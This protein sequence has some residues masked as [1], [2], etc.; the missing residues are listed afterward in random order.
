MTGVL[1]VVLPVFGLLGL[2]YAAARFGLLSYQAGEGLSEFVFTFCIPPLIFRTM[3]TASL[4]DSQPWGYWGAYFLGLALTWALAMA[5]GRG[6]FKLDPRENV[7]AGFSAAQSNTA[8]VGIP[9]LLQAF[10]D[11]GAVPLFLLL[12][13]H[14]PVTLTSATLLMEGPHGLHPLQLAKRL[15]LNPILLGLMAG[16]AFRGLGAP[17][18]GALRV[19]VDYLANAAVPCALVAMGLALRRYGLRADMKLTATIA[20]LKLFVHPAAVYLLAFK[21]FAMPPV[22][23]GVAVL[24]AAMPSGVNAYLFAERYRC[25]VAL[26]S[27]AIALSTIVS[28]ASAAFWLWMLGVGS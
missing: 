26:S 17:Y 4:P 22:W 25:G 16:L 7:V 27:S 2:G 13:V 14:L 11:A 8:L 18:S 21:V 9:L 15:L 20:A 1:V 19:I 6:V 3:A 23:A 24:F 12:A 5:I 10:G 28:V